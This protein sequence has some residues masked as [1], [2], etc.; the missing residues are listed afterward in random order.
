M[1][2][3]GSLLRRTA[4]VGHV[5]ITAVMTLIA[6]MP[7]ISCRCPDGRLK[8]FCFS[9]L[10]DNSGCCGKNCCQRQD[11][12][13]CAVLD[14]SVAAD[15][16]GAHTCC[17]QSGHQR[18]A[19]PGDSRHHI[20]RNGCVRKLVQAADQAMSQNDTTRVTELTFAFTLPHET[21][22]TLPLRPAG[23]TW[24]P[25]LLPPPTDLTIVLQRFVI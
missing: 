4:L 6:G 24:Q 12:N 11:G 17:A 21:V 13:R 25:Y 10:G 19:E 8:P 5:G 22:T 23:H 3:M 2:F 7:H 15:D 14:A 16:A 18:S 9:F 1:T 20:E